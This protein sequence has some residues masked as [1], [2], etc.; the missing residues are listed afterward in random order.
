MSEKYVRREFLERLGIGTAGLIAG[1]YLATPSG[2]AANETIQI[3]CIG[4]GGRCRQL[5]DTVKTIPGVKIVAVCDVRDDN[6]AKGKETA[7]GNVPTTRYYEELLARK[8]VDAIICGTADHWH[9]PITIDACKAGKDVYVEKPLTHDLKE[10]KAV[11]RAKNESGRIVQVGMQQRSMPHLIEARQIVQSGV[12]GPIRKV[13]LTWNR[14]TERS[15]KMTYD[16]KPEEVDWKRFVGPARKQP[17]DVYR[18]RNWR[19][20]WDFGGGIFT[21][22]MVHFIDVA[23]WFLDLEHPTNASSIGNWFTKAGEWQ[24]PDT[25]QTL[26]QYDKPETQIYFE[27]TFCNARNAAMMEFMGTE[28]TLYCDRGR[29]TVIPEK[30]KKVEPKEL[31]LGTG[32]LGQDFYDKPNG[33]LIHLGN[34]LECIRS[35]ETPNSPVEAGVHSAGAAHLANIALRTGE[36][37]KWKKGVA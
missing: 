28:A 1:G 13:H 27:G 2:Y 6:L 32:P 29:Y 19:F 11:I 25:V 7:G 8:D 23:H 35:R 3:A 31:V 16:M 12:L 4:T 17:L 24:T 34:W 14:N 36:V 5:M 15:P 37:A 20:F 18:L 21:D 10:G 9:V 33:E 22:L 26:L 30:N